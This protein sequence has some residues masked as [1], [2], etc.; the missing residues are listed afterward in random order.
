MMECPTCGAAVPSYQCV[1]AMA[2]L[3]ERLIEEN[4]VRPERAAEL[5][6]RALNLER[7]HGFLTDQELKKQ[8]QEEDLLS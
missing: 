6:N 2:K 7:G 3:C 1:Y 4:Y 8:Q 5:R